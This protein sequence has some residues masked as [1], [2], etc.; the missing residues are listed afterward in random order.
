MESIDFTT[1]KNN[2]I[3]RIKNA[4]TISKLDQI[5]K[6]RDEK[7]VE[8][9]EKETG[10]KYPKDVPKKDFTDFQQKRFKIIDGLDIS[11]EMYRKKEQ[12]SPSHLTHGPSY[13]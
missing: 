5:E 7:M 3:E 6:E 2:F 11:I 8:I 9:V 13:H 10:Y 12:I 1:L 4:T